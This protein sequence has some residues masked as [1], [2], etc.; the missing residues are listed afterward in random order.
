MSESTVVIRLAT[1]KDFP[2]ILKLNEEN[3]EVLSPMDEERIAFFAKWAELFYVAEVNGE[4]AAFLIALREGLK[5]GSEN[6][7]WF[8]RHYSQFLYVDRIVIEEPYRKMGLGRRL[9]QKVMEHAYRTQV[10]AVTAE[11]DTEPVYNAVSLKFH[12]AM[13]F[14][15]VGTQYIRD[16]KIKVSLQAAESK[17]G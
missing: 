11:V 3:V 10:S 17:E 13:G 16:G 8:L 14:K 12:A 2:L 9:Y 7:K 4:F 6:Y 5:Y 15:E 1:E